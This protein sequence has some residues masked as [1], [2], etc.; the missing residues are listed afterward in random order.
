ML[1]M[2][3]VFLSAAG[4][5]GVPLR[6]SGNLILQGIRH[7]SCKKILRQCAPPLN[8]RASQHSAASRK[9]ARGR[10]RLRAGGEGTGQVAA[11]DT[12]CRG[13]GRNPA[14]ASGCGA[15]ERRGHETE[16]PSKHNHLSEGAGEA[17]RRSC[18]RPLRPLLLR[19]QYTTGQKA[20]KGGG[21]PGYGRILTFLCRHPSRCGR[22]RENAAGC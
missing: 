15:S 7:F 14:A 2:Q 8:R 22:A 6:K 16:D 5:F 18:A 9:A 1:N 4:T 13:S 10:I 21:L 12:S 20:R 11:R 17:L 19:L 3:Q